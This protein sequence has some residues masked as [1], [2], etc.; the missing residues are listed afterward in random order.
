MAC[1]APLLTGCFYLS[2]SQTEV[3]YNGSL[4]ADANVGALKLSNVFIVAS[5]KGAPGAMQGMVTNSSAAPVTLAIV[6]GSTKAQIVV[7]AD[8][9]VRLD[10]KTSGNSS[11]TVTAIKVAQTPV[12]P[13]AKATV[14]FAAPGTGLTPVPVP[15]LLPDQASGS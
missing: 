3:S 5:T 10:G 13:G 14:N 6:V 11:R 12:I 2:P 4:G 9:A 15:V 7:P 8:T 1:A